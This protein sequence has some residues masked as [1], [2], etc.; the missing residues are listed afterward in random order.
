MNRP[1]MFKT[2]GIPD[3][4]FVQNDAVPGPTK[5]EIRVITISKARLEE[6][7]VVID[8][9]C[10]TGGLTVE[11]ALQVGAKGRV[12]AF[13]EDE[14]AVRLTRANVEKFG[15]QGNVQIATGRAPQAL[16][17]LPNADAILIGGG[18]TQLRTIL[19]IASNK[20]KPAG[21]IVVNAIL[22][23]TAT[24][25]I[26][27]LKSL[28]FTDIDVAHIS[29]AKGKQISSGTMMMARNPITVISAT[30]I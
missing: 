6:G 27:E 22:L 9:G 18:G 15:V 13:D 5:E 7:S 12:Y 1:W 8:V 23:E 11:A 16:L 4:D 26:E 2:P 19:Q 28:G 30:K 21:R 24:T 17:M 29:V 25:A 20:L 3:E 14:A 10:G